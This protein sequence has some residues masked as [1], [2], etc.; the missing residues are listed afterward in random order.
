MRLALSVGHGDGLEDTAERLAELESAG[1]DMAWVGEAYGFDAPTLLGYLAARTTRMEL[2]AGILNVFSRPATLI[3]Q[4]AASLDYVSGGRAVLGL[5]TSGPQ[6]IEGW[7]GVPYGRPLQRTREVI[8]ICRQVWRR[9]RIDHHGAIDI[10]LGPGQGQGVG[11][12]LKI[13]AHPV[14]DRIPIWVASLGPRN[15]ELTA[16][17]AEG[18]LSLMFIPARAKA[19]WGGP[20]AAGLARRAPELGPLEIQA[21]GPV[22]IGEDVEHLRDRARPMVARYLGGMG[23]RQ[24]NYYNDLACRYGFEAEAAVIQDLYLDGHRQEAE[25]AVPDEFL[26][27]TSLIGP[28]GYVRDRLAEYAEA[29]VTMLTVTPMAGDPVE[30]VAQLKEW[31]A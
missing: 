9:E 28:P 31:T 12:P 17:L 18:W 23:T 3:A 24:V 19:V 21:G 6:V 16:E 13:A 11:K 14:R 4:A 30:V 7:Y 25:A 2:G 1:L 8:E 20:L 15:V 5:G 29:G 26:E 10:P 27:Q 22:A